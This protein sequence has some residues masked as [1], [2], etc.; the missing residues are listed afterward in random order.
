MSDT[1]KVLFILFDNP[2]NTRK[3]VAEQLCKWC[4]DVVSVVPVVSVVNDKYDKNDQDD[5]TTRVSKVAHNLINVMRRLSSGDNPKTKVD[6]SKVLNTYSLTELGRKTVIDKIEAFQKEL[7]EMAKRKAEEEREESFVDLFKRYINQNY[8]KSTISESLR[9]GKKYFIA[10]LTDMARFDYFLTDFIL[11]HNTDEMISYMIQ[12]IQD[13]FI[14]HDIDIRGFRVLFKNLPKSTEKNITNL[15]AKDIDQ[16]RIVPGEIRSRS[17]TTLKVRYAR[18]ECPSCAN[19]VTVLQLDQEFKEPYQCGCGRKGKFKLKHKETVDSLRLTICDLYENLDSNEV[20]EEINVLLDE[21]LFD[22]S[23]LAEGQKIKVYCIPRQVD[24]LKRTGKK[25]IHMEK[26]LECFGIEKLEH[27]YAKIFLKASVE[28]KFKE[29]KSDPI[30]WHRKALFSDLHDVDMPTKVAIIGMYGSLHILYAGA[31]GR[32]KSD[33]C[34]RICQVALRGSFVECMDASSSGI[35]GSVTKN[36]F[37]GKYSLDGG[38]FRPMHPGGIVTLDEINRDNDK[39]I[40]K[41]ILGIMQRKRLNIHKANTRVDL[42]CDV[43]IWA[44]VNPT[45][46]KFDINRTEYENFNILRPLWDRFDLI[47]Y[48]NNKLDYT[49]ETLIL[50]LL[51]DKKKEFQIDAETFKILKKYQIKAQLIDVKFRDSDYVALGKVLQYFYTQINTEASYRSLMFMKRFLECICRLHHRTHPIEQDF[52][53]MTDLLMQLKQERQLFGQMGIEHDGIQSDE[54]IIK[55]VLEEFEANNQ[56]DVPIGM[57]AEATKKKGIKE[58][59]ISIC[60]DK[61]KK[62][63]DIY[64]PRSG[65]IS[66]IQ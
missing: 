56:K 1:D 47:V 50:S 42:P 17:K 37:T 21:D 60:I 61:L 57:L 6:K 25:S 20:P 8:I 27:D 14:E 62:A 58:F 55:E 54:D 32:G 33:I 39:L 44:T 34:D 65:F 10:D 4:R 35:L 66:R 23:R 40:Q 52:K 7:Y 12:L 3:E 19:V 11:D 51:K 36:H 53:L 43:S 15:R 64:E 45:F 2:N 5:M 49:D 41:V 9:V 28:E 29:T 26:V 46:A 30:K 38:V 31:P 48:F 13:R 63:G 59:K 24:I 16:L 18:F 22:F